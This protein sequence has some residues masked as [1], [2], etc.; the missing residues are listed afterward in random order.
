MA[1]ARRIAR[2]LILGE[3]GSRGKHVVECPNCSYRPQ[4]PD[5]SSSTNAS[6]STGETR[7]KNSAW[8]SVGYLLEVL[9]EDDHDCG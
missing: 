1:D 2:W 3:N 5:T 8:M 7:F 6:W 9:A 4:L